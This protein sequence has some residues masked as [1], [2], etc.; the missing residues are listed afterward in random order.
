MDKNVNNNSNPEAIVRSL[1]Q[2]MSSNDADKIRSLFHENAK[3]AYGDGSWK[4]GEDF[5]SWLQ[6][7]IIDR[8]GHVDDAKFSIKENQVVVTGQYSS[9][10]YTNKANF[11]FF[12][13]GDKILSWQM[14]Y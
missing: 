1:I 10:G 11:L 13:E 12:V 9:L 3:Q 6:S 5:F 2:A 8:K 14:R 4:K 7:D